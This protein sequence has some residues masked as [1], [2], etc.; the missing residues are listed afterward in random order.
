MSAAFAT[1]IVPYSPHRTQYAYFD[2]AMPSA[3]FTTPP[4]ASL[5]ASSISNAPPLAPTKR[6]DGSE[7]HIEWPSQIADTQKS[8]LSS[9][10]GPERSFFSA[11]RKVTL[12]R[13]HHERT[14][15]L[16]ASSGCRAS[17]L[18]FPVITDAE[19]RNAGV[20]DIAQIWHLCQEETSLQHTH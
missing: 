4:P 19:R 16:D 15:K 10:A 9:S 7:L 2:S 14:N 1:T 20:S 17:K 13:P 18:R 12:S 5:P 3:P 6:L 8:A 11:E